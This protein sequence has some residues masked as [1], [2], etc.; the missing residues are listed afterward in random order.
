MI[1]VF[2]LV[3]WVLTGYWV[4]VAVEFLWHGVHVRLVQQIEWR[5]QFLGEGSIHHSCL[6]CSVQDN[7][8]LD[9]QA[10]RVVIVEIFLFN[11]RLIFNAIKMST[12]Q[13]MSTVTGS[14]QQRTCWDCVQI[15]YLWWW[16]QCDF[17][18]RLVPK[19]LVPVG[20]NMIL[21]HR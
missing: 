4:V 16:R 12:I 3:G 6:S 19:V 14:G 15:R 8:P 20:A 9:T 5:R 10:G 2:A 11:G 13:K 1:F 7:G 17:K 21:G 18:D